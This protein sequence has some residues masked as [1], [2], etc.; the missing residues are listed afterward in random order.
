M[1]HK[2]SITIYKLLQLFTAVIVLGSCGST[3]MQTSGQSSVADAGPQQCLVFNRIEDV[4]IAD[5]D[6]IIY[7]TNRQIFTNTLA[8]TCYGIESF[9]NRIVFS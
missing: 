6:T 7:F 1:K 4:K 2:T 3:G 5:D 9:S 8:N